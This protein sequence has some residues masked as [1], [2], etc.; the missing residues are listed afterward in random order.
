M[1]VPKRYSLKIAVFILVIGSIIFLKL[2]FANSGHHDQTCLPAPLPLPLGVHKPDATH[3]SSFSEA[4]QHR[5]NANRSILMAYFDAGALNMTLNFYHSSLKPHGVTHFLLVSSSSRACAAVQAE[6]LA[7]FLYMSDADSEK[8]SVYM[9]KDFVRKM[10]IRTYM[11][12]EALK[13]GFNVLHTDVDVVYFTNPLTEVEKE[14]PEKDCDLAPLWDSIVYNEGFVFI[15]SSPAGVRAFEDMKVI[16]ET[17]NKD[18]QVALNTVIKRGHKYG[19]RFK[20]LPVTQYLSGK[21]FYEDTERVFGN[22]APGCHNCKVAHNNWIVSIEAKVYRFREMLQ[23]IHDGLDGYYTNPDRRYL[24]YLNA[25][26]SNTKGSETRDMEVKA[27]RNALAVSSLLNRTLI[28]P[29]FH[30][31]TGV[32]CSLLNHLRLTEFDRAYRGEYR[33]STFLDH[34]LVPKHIKESISKFVTIATDDAPD[35]SVYVPRDTKNGA[36]SDEILAWFSGRNEA[37]LRFSTLYNAFSRFS[38]RRTQMR[39]QEK[40]DSVDLKGNYRQYI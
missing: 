12:L 13:L 25:E 5:A 8:E 33:E 38:D 10:N 35:K 3:F 24:T 11:I 7:C 4:V 29:R 36:T 2:L 1:C 30:T 31:K 23:W 28:L 14:C 34:H 19:L 32:Q 18:D 6:G 40:F 22:S 27:L 15:R 37:V 26:P 16:A 20:K 17:T 9:S 39:F 21:A